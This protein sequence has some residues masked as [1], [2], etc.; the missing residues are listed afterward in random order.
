MAYALIPKD[1]TRI[2]TK[3]L[4]GLTRRQVICFGFGALLGVPV[5]LLTRPAIGDSAA[6]YIMI[7]V[8]LPFFMF[9][10]YEK[11]G[12]PLE[13]ILHQ[14][15]QAKFIRPKRRPY[16]TNNAYAALVCS[17]DLRNEVNAIVQGKGKTGKHP[18]R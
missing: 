5:F 11:N 16:Q 4:F 14:I 3:F 2:K 8:M 12:L 17:A 15:V 6:S 9:A 18:P 10:M 1:L 7:A 13:V